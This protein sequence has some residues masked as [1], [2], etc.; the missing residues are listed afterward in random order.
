MKKKKKSRYWGYGVFMENSEWVFIISGYKDLEILAKIDLTQIIYSKP[1]ENIE[2][3]CCV[4]RALN[5]NRIEEF[6]SQKCI[7]QILEKYPIETLIYDIN[8]GI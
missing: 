7:E 8:Q 3:L 4:C 1:I 2:E 6:D 5:E